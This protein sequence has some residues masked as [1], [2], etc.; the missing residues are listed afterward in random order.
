V[1]DVKCCNE[2]HVARQHHADCPL[3][4]RDRV[5]RAN[6]WRERALAAEAERDVARRDADE[7][8]DL[9]ERIV[10]ALDCGPLANVADA[11]VTMRSRAERAERVAGEALDL[12]YVV[13]GDGWVN[14]DEVIAALRKELEKP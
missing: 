5:E 12:L 7:L 6:Q 1:A 3:M 10:E 2:W 4:A 14:R 9:V 11:A 8:A 13:S